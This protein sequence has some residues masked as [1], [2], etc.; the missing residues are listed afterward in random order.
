L[1]AR[2]EIDPSFVEFT[3]LLLNNE[4]WRE[5]LATIPYERRLLLLP[6]CLR[7]EEHCPAPFDELGLLCKKCGMCSIEDLQEE[8]ERMGYAVLVAEGSPIV[9][10]IIETGQ[11]E[12]IVGV[13]CLSV[14]ERVYGYMEAAAIPGVA[15]PLLQDDCLDTN[16]DLDW[17]WDAVHLTSDDR[18]RRLDLGGLRDEV[19]TFFDQ[20]VLEELLGEATTETEK[21]GRAYLA[22]AGKRWRP[23][24]AVAVHQA[25][26]EE[27]GGEL[28]EA[29]KKMAV[30]VEC[31]HKASLVHDDIED[32]DDLRDGQATL[33]ARHGVP[34]ALN[35][36]DYL[37]GEGYRLLS[38]VDVPADR[39][40]EMLRLAAEGHRTLCL[41]Q[42][43]DLAWSRDPRPLKAQQ[44]VAIF[45]HKTAPAFET[46]LRLGAA[47]A[48]APE[49]LHQTLRAYSDA[50]GIAYQIRDD[51]GE[52]REASAEDR[53]PE[54][55]PTLVWALAHEA[56][57]KARKKEVAELW[58][59]AAA[60]SV[61]MPAAEIHDLL[62]ELGAVA[63]AE[64]LLEAYKDEAIRS[65]RLLDNANV[66]GLLRRV[67][68]KIFETLEIEGWC[69]EHEARNAAS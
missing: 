47:C 54:G 62:A 26:Q 37:L 15:I 30:A 1:S 8:A 50:L 52:L 31:F 59:G 67:L 46:A 27:P 9:M 32:G 34:V 23:F 53:P 35:V 24:L 5:S 56:A 58:R 66:K 49:E 29:V 61:E 6:K 40:L 4:L 21:L 39:R 13:S 69:S 43:D 19:A 51:L 18:T 57:K 60:G 2:H 16:V 14:L 65:L 7:V 25:L 44:V 48:G 45:R 63:R 22:A 3:A 28:S 42:G 10:A 68:G 17:I 20:L 64:E 36:G 12:A 41:G 33:H 11:I 55:R 38:E